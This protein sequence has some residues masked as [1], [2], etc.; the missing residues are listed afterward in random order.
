MQL[1]SL[2]RDYD[3][4]WP[5]LTLSLLSY[6]DTFNVGVSIVAPACFIQG[7]NFYMLYISTIAEPVRSSE[8]PQ[9]GGRQATC[10]PLLGSSSTTGM[11]PWSC[12]MQTQHLEA[13]STTNVSLLMQ[14]IAVMLCGGIY[15]LAHT[16]HRWLIASQE[17]GR[18]PKLLGVYPLAMTAEKHA[19]AITFFRKMKARYMLLRHSCGCPG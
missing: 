5:S 9:I 4:E 16:C 10:V 14:A 1:L 18:P 2:L 12:E 17:S 11:V 3:V 6:S 8:G 7:W 15:V 19:A 13:H